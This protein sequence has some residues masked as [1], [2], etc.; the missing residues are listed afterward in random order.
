MLA[1]THTIQRTWSAED[2]FGSVIAEQEVRILFRMSSDGPLPAFE[3]VNI[4]VE[5]MAQNGELR[6]FDALP[7]D[8]ARFEAWAENDLQ[9][10][11]LA[12]ALAAQREAA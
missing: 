8:H 9:D 2:E 3:I 5:V 4:H 1:P 11:M 6:W 12:E 7:A 10:A